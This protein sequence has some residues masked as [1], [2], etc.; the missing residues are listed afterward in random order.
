MEGK[1]G[2]R[3]TGCVPVSRGS[4]IR[5]AL[6]GVL[7]VQGGAGW[8]ARAETAARWTVR[9]T[10]KRWISLV[11]W[12]VGPA[13]LQSLRLLWEEVEE[14]E[15]CLS[16]GFREASRGWEVEVVGRY[17]YRPGPPSPWASVGSSPPLVVVG[18]RPLVEAALGVAPVGPFCWR[19]RLLSWPLAAWWRLTGEEVAA[20]TARDWTPMLARLAKEDATMTKELEAATGTPTGRWVATEAVAVFLIH[21]RG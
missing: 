16:K 12:E 14:G 5:S 7:R 11:A 18:G 20:A 19:R 21:P 15:V 17:R 6:W 3:A 10:V 13:V 4:L 9:S 8:E 2:C 1:W